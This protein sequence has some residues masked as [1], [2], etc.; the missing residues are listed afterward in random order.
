M[1]VQNAEDF[2][3]VTAKKRISEKSGLDNR[4]P[5][6]GKSLDA[7]LLKIGEKRR[8]LRTFPLLVALF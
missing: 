4:F 5:T 6:P 2:R 7:P 8:F 3:Y 1:G